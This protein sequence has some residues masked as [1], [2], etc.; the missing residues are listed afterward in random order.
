MIIIDE[1]GDLTVTIIEYEDQPIRPHNQAYSSQEPVHEERII[2]KTE[3]FL[4]CRQTIVDSSSY[5][6]VQLATT[7]AEARQST[8]TQKEDVVTAMEI[9]FRAVHNA[10]IESTYD[11]PLSEMWNLIAAADKYE[12]D[13]RKLNDWFAQWHKKNFK[14]DLDTRQLV[15]PCYR[16]DHAVG[17]AQATKALAYNS[18]GHIEEFNPTK[19]Y[20]F[21]LPP[22]I[23]RESNIRFPGLAAYL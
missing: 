19:H 14:A 1:S 7:F 12:W 21:H 23:I 18:L 15:Y 3:D 4:V 22:R 8:V 6:K 5:F 9:W 11:V 20:Q 13:I 16:F 17:F 2:R 10:I